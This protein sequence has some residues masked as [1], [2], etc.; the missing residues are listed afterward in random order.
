MKTIEE[1]KLKGYEALVK[2]LGVLDAEK[3]IAYIIREPFDYTEWQRDLFK[4][5]SAKEISR[6]AMEPRRKGE[7]RGIKKE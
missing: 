5:K 6:D 3:F 2:K 4:G 1:I 7:Q